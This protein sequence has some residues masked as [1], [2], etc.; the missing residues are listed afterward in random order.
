M[1][2]NDVSQ[3][4]DVLGSFWGDFEDKAYVQEMWQ[5]YY[6]VV[7]GLASKSLGLRQSIGFRNMPHI[8][9]DHNVAFDVIY[10]YSNSNYS[11]L[12]NVIIESGVGGYRY[13]YYID[14]GTVSIPTLTYFY[15]S[16]SGTLSDQQT[17][18]EG[19]D[20]YIERMERIRFCGSP[21]FEPNA[22]QSNFSGNTLLADTVY[23][24]NPA[25]WGIEA[26]RAGLTQSDLIDNNYNSFVSGYA[27]SGAARNVLDAQHFKYLVWGMQDALR[28]QPTLTNVRNIYGIARGLPFAYT[29]GIFNSGL[30]G[31]DTRN[32]PI[33]GYYTLDFSNSGFI[34]TNYSALS[35]VD[36]TFDFTLKFGETSTQNAINV[37]SLDSHSLWLTLRSTGI[38]MGVTDGINTIEAIN[39][40]ADATAW[41]KY[42]FKRTVNSGIYFY[43]DDALVI[44]GFMGWSPSMAA[45]NLIFGT[46]TTIDSFS[47]NTVI[48]NTNA[49]TGQL[50]QIKI[51]NSSGLANYYL[52]CVP[53]YTTSDS[54]IQDL[55]ASGYISEISGNATWTQVDMPLMGYT[56]LN[57]G[58]PIKRFDV[59]LSGVKVYDY[60]NGP[61]VIS[62]ITDFAIERY[63][64]IAINDSGINFHGT[65]PFNSGFLIQTLDGYIPTALTYGINEAVYSGIFIAPWGNDSNNGSRHFPVRTYSGAA[66]LTSGQNTIWFRQGTY[67]E[68]IK[69]SLL[70]NS[71]T[72]WNEPFRIKAFPGE[73]VVI[74]QDPP[75]VG[76][77][78]I[79]F[80]MP[81]YDYISVEDLIVDGK[82][83]NQLLINMAYSGAS[84]SKVYNCIIKNSSYS[85]AVVSMGVS[86]QILSRNTIYNDNWT[87]QTAID[88]IANDGSGVAAH[89]AIVSYNEIYNF[90]SGIR[91]NNINETILVSGAA[92]HHNKIYNT[93]IGISLDGGESTYIH[94]NLIEYC[95]WG[96]APGYNR[97][98]VTPYIFNNTIRYCLSTGVWDSSITPGAGIR[99]GAGETGTEFCVSG[100]IINN[101]MYN[102]A[103]GYYDPSGILDANNF[104]NIHAYNM[105]NDATLPTSGFVS[106]DTNIVEA[107]IFYYNFLKAEATGD[108]RLHPYFSSGY[109]SGADLSDYSYIEDLNIDYSGIARVGYSGWDI[110]AF[111]FIA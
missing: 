99:M 6:N 55:T 79:A 4:W 93:R 2:T 54:T 30:I 28:K 35:N 103:S 17:L 68:P 75:L 49:F 95:G 92:I 25:L 110:G 59:L 52:Q 90:G 42:T 100:F 58:E 11:G 51:R 63:K 18:I 82:N 38:A 89:N 56:Y 47:Q 76:S 81:G 72:S 15:A 87:N 53:Q 71:G 29:S 83:Q 69:T 105:A 86:G 109:N 21:P 45:T 102:C 74:V 78:V 23:R 85:G 44:S 70:L 62:G 98:T 37:S 12:V 36:Y 88:L 77:G 19:T 91:I 101:S 24:L 34:Q 84:N 65:L 41:H 27:S 43:I 13:E 60:I 22:S 26:L 20:Y 16:D 106:A 32:Y 14:P 3:F 61:E 107:L 97:R 40:T 80:D 108:F 39:T 31:S 33:S 73:A 94:N 8:I 104:Y 9:T 57:S 67:N 50:A 1:R 111:E 48:D 66:L 7:S 10:D 46:T 64:H 5:G 96:V